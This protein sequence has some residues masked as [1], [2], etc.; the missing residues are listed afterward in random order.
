VNHLTTTVTPGNVWRAE[1]G[2]LLARL[3]F[4]ADRYVILKLKNS[5]EAAFLAANLGK[6]LCVT[7]EP[8]RGA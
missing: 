2:T 3:H 4:D 5:D 8:G 6:S 1:D 7:L